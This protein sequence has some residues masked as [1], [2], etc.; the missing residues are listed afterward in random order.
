LRTGKDAPLNEA[1]SASDKKS[2]TKKVGR[3]KKR[4]LSGHNDETPVAKR[5]EKEE[6]TVTTPL[7]TPTKAVVAAS[8]VATSAAT[9]SPVGVNRRNAVLFTRKKQAAAVS[10]PE[11]REEDSDGVDDDLENKETEVQSPGNSKSFNNSK[12]LINPIRQKL[13]FGNILNLKLICVL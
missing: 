13:S 10:T 9:K 12:L 4:S 11:P 6:V 8:N 3:G 5:W 1:P 2:T 7:K